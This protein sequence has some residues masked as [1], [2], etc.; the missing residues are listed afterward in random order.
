VSHFELRTYEVPDGR[1][2]EL[3][4]RFR[5]ETWRYFA[6]HGIDVL[7]YWQ[8]IV[9]GLPDESRLLYLVRFAD[10]EQ[11]RQAWSQLRTDPEWLGVRQ[12]T[13]RDGALTG[14]VSSIALRSIPGL[15]DLNAQRAL[16]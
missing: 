10:A 8:P 6:R 5:S 9:D 13:E 7:G 2:A 4:E 1:F 12:R 11:A 3:A 16:R 15:P 14:N